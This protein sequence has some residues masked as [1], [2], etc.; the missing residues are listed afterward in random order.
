MLIHCYKNGSLI[1]TVRCRNT[2]IIIS[3]PSTQLVLMQWNHNWCELKHSQTCLHYDAVVWLSLSHAMKSLWELH[4]HIMYV[5]SLSQSTLLAV[6]WN[7]IHQ[8]PGRCKHILILR[9]S[10]SPLA[11]IWNKIQNMIGRCKHI[12]VVSVS[13]NSAIITSQT[14]TVNAFTSSFALIC[15]RECWKFPSE[16]YFSWQGTI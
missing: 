7:R 2:H 3:T 15:R 9:V 6:I 8:I 11:F 14:D 16:F 5:S 12:M 4:S 1:F 13:V 10:V